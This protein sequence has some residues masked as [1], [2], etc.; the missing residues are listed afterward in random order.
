VQNPTQRTL[1][2]SFR[3]R[4]AQMGS[5]FESLS[6]FGCTYL[7]YTASHRKSSF[8]DRMLWCL[9]RQ[10]NGE[11]AM[12]EKSPPHPHIAIVKA[13]RLIAMSFAS[14]SKQT[15][16]L[17]RVRGG[18]QIFKFQKTSLLSSR[19]GSCRGSDIDGM[20]AGLVY[21]LRVSAFKFPAHKCR[22]DRLSM[23]RLYRLPG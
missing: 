4:P 10:C 9:P 11:S 5:E 23:R 8:W 15:F 18:S 1:V 3:K 17:A 16:G 22:R 20:K 21:C 2:W 19:F 7:G 14:T 12:R 13:C 6:T